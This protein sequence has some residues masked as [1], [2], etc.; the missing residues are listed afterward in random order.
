MNARRD[1]SL[2]SAIE[3][4]PLASLRVEAV[5]DLA[6]GSFSIEATH[7]DGRHLAILST[8]ALDLDLDDPLQR[9]FGDYEL[10]ELIGEGGMGV[11]Y[12]ARQV[13][14]ERDVAV[15]LLAAGPWASKNFIERFRLEAQNAAR[16]QHP[17]IVA[18][19]EVGS[20][21]H[22]HFFS[23]RLIVGP[24]LAHQLKERT[25]FAPRR[26][27][28]LVRT[29]A[30]AVDYAHRLGVLHLDLKPANILLDEDGVPHVADFGLARRLEQGLAPDSDEVSGTPS[31]MAPEQARGKSKLMSPATDIW[32]L[33]AILYELTTGRPPFLGNS[34]HATL[35]L[36]VEGK[37]QSPRDHVPQLPRDLEA[38]MLKCMAPEVDARYKT[39]RALADDLAAFMDGRMVRA[40][41]LNAIQRTKRWAQRE[42]KLATAALFAF[43][44]LLIG[45]T[46]TTQQWRRA[47]DQRVRA[48][49]NALVSRE[50]SWQ[51]RRES[52]LR[53]LV[54]GKGFEALPLLTQN[55]EE[56]ELAGAER[57]VERREV[58]MILNEGVTLIDR[59]IIPDAQPMTTSL[60]SDGSLLAIGLNDMTV[61]WYDTKTLTERGRVDLTELPNSSGEF[62]VPMYLQFIGNHKLQVSLLWYEYQPSP[63]TENMY[64]VDLD[65]SS[66]VVPPNDVKDFTHLTFNADGRY[67]LVFDANASVELW[68]TDP[69][70]KLSPAATQIE[71]GLPW[72]LGRNLDIGVV[73]TGSVKTLQRFDPY[74]PEKRTLLRVPTHGYTT[75]WTENNAGTQLAMGDS[76]G[77]I[78]LVDLKTL[79]AREL[80]APSGAILTWL[81]YS[82][83][84]AW[85]VT[86]RKDGSAFAFDIASGQTLHAGEMHQD[87]AL[88]GASISHRD[89]TVFLEGEGDAALWRL[90]NPSLEGVEAAR[91][92]A[93]PT[94]S[95]PAS[96]YWAGASM[97]AGLL[98][99]ADMNGEVRIWR[100]PHDTTL[101]AESPGNWAANVYFDGE[102]VVDTAY[103]KIRVAT[104]GGQSP[105]AW[106]ELPQPVGFA[107]LSSDARTLVATAGSEMYVFDTA[108]MKLRYRPIRMHATAQRFALSSDGAFAVLSFGHNEEDGFHEELRVYDLNDGGRRV[109]AVSVQGPLRQLELSPNGKRVLATGSANGSV[110]V[111]E[112]P[113]LDQTGSY[114]NKSSRP[115]LWASFTED[116]QTLWMVTRDI[117]EASGNDSELV[118]WDLRAKTIV[119]RRKVPG[120][121]PIGVATIG[122]APLLAARDRLLLNP[123]IS[124]ERSSPRLHGGD[125][126]TTFAISHDRR[127]VAHAYGRFV[128]LY[129]TKTLEPVGPPLAANMRALDQIWS[130][131]FSPDDS[132]LIANAASS[133]TWLVWLIGAD[134]R[135]AA[136]IRQDTNCS[137]PL[138][139]AC[140]C[141]VSPTRSS[142]KPCV[143]AIRADNSP[144]RV[145]R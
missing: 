88:H 52:A 4:D 57:M 31:Y 27:A 26:A 58:G 24:S 128:Q 20:A 47:E 13:S 106:T 5:A 53:L 93:N 38:I 76:E 70:R 132:R 12:R 89:R 102:H 134:E 94:R 99:T 69:W 35:Q 36:V 29:V 127:L 83:D 103:N 142:D 85:L 97:Q 41:P 40:R 64:L 143:S 8:D 61:R 95:E 32:G 140:A 17:N 59:M 42:P 117:D 50:L 72:L 126:T 74:H 144:M 118:R 54:D 63:S 123:G 23:M 129:D 130:L 119:E 2:L 82:E 136:D 33:G 71:A 92:I 90:P 30:E 21:E 104:V 43:A 16:M 101:P 131:A 139:A 116:C 37:L 28:A 48:E 79:T 66:V 86:A 45:L 96:I 110:D 125:P 65:K 39:A 67:A 75:S 138:P 115:V 124:D 46:A 15:K 135:V 87:F 62:M 77:R 100:M 7:V 98:S 19:Y 68:Q 10:L 51:G 55:I 56:E 78:N 9:R 141:F 22:L 121:Y 112:M 109:G 1:D 122:D 14:L 80:P 25:R 108:T 114:P 60:S 44:A 145:H 18:I 3:A 113:S 81:A 105:T 49:Q 111:F 120:I 91:L 137:L 11:V 107:Q 73:F 133:H 6:F 84:D 34:P